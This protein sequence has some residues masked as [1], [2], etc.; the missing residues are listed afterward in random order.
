MIKQIPNM[1]TS[2]NILCGSLAV[3]FAATGDLVAAAIFI[4]LGIFFDFFDGFAA[5]LLNAHSEIGLQMDSLADVI[6]SGLAPAVVMVQLMNISFIGNTQNL[7]EVFSKSGWS[8]EYGNYLSLI[9]LIIVVGAAY[10]L[11]KF[12]VD[13]RQTEGF[14]GLPTPANAV[15]ILSFPL[16]LKFQ[17]SDRAESILLNPWFLIGIS[18]L[19]C[20][21]M[22]SELRMFSLKFKTINIK[23]NRIRYIFLLVSLILL[24]VFKYWSIP[25]I[26]GFYILFSLLN[27]KSKS[28]F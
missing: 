25:L 17:Y 16:I 6:T 21:L 22:N 8:V 20:I 3:L 24:V 10:R 1:I 19:G 13:K 28:V 4:F 7:T 14:I 11:A 23:E 27:K 18:L 12:N 5:R 2:L 15:L 9:G 26:I